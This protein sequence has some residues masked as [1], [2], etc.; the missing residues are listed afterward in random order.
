MEKE[1]KKPALTRAEKAKRQ[2][3][4]V[5][6]LLSEKDY[7]WNDL[8]DEATKKYK[9]TH[10]D[11]QIDLA[12]LKG[13]IGSC[14]S[15]LEEKGEVAFDKKTSVCSLVKQE[16]KKKRGRKKK[17]EPVLEKKE[18]Q[19]PKTE[20][21]TEEK[22]EEISPKKQAE[23]P[24]KPRAK[25]Q[26]KKQETPVLKEVKTE[27]KP[28]EKPQPK[29]EEKADEKPQVKTEE[30]AEKSVPVFDLTAV[31]GEKKAEKKDE[32]KAEKKE[33]EKDG[34]KQQEKKP[35]LPEFSFLG[36][37]ATKEKPEQKTEK[38]EQKIEQK[39]AEEKP[40]QKPQ[41]KKE[42][43]KPQN[44]VKA[45]VE[46]KKVAQPQK[47]LTQKEKDALA[48]AKLSPEEK[49]KADFLKRLRALGGEY[50]EYYSVYLLERYSLKN[51]RRLEMLKVSGGNAD[52]GIDGE[53]ELTDKF[54]FRE[55]LYIQAKNWD[56]SKGDSEKWTVGETL[57][58]QFVG[59]VTCRQAKEGRRKCRGVFVTTSHFT[60]GAKAI[61][62]SL[63]A[64]F[65][66]YDGDDVFETAKEC[67]FGLIKKDGRWQL[68]E[69]LLS[70]EK[71]FFDLL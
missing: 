56:D 47:R 28:Q 13:K 3:A 66:G 54:G 33:E 45:S 38:V 63:N 15:L 29:A 10:L 60:D 64:D 59:A 21:K 22:S 14:F 67:S 69:K 5:L 50:F 31:L 55:T 46:I 35:V 2:K 24:K 18:E 70:G 26:T 61:L 53:L 27:E 36:N 48:Y 37:N 16:E 6:G 19:P 1:E 8:L 68:D 65:V 11:E 7:K 51:G 42:E 39:A 62:E 58:Q 40:Q 9:E 4:I 12:D 43:K 20:E 71:A 32:K 44:G 49:L 23:K 25:K 57:L 41:E 34:A 52:G 30:K 17:D